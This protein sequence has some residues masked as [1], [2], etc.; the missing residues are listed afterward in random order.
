[1][2]KSQNVPIAPFSADIAPIFTLFRGKPGT[3]NDLFHTKNSTRPEDGIQLLQIRLDDRVLAIGGYHVL[4]T[5]WN[6]CNS[7]RLYRVGVT[8]SEG[9]TKKIKCSD[10]LE[11]RAL[12]PGAYA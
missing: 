10:E 11:H 6:Y 7:A 4:C 8:N 9:R 2:N 3:K 5:S 12:S 1:M